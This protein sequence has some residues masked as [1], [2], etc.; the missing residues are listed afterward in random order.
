VLFKMFGPVSNV[1][2]VALAAPAVLLV[3][4]YLLCTVDCAVSVPVSG[5]PFHAHFRESQVYYSTL[6]LDSLSIVIVK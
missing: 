3:G 2:L 6:N 1:L 5:R 4:R